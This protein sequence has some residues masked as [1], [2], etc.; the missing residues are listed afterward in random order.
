MNDGDLG[1]LL[2]I[3]NLGRVE[4]I[5]SDQTS[6]IAA[7]CEGNYFG[8]ATF[9]LNTRRTV[10]VKAVS[11]VQ[12]SQLSKSDFEDVLSNFPGQYEIIT[13]KASIQREA[14]GKVNAAVAKNLKKQKISRG[15]QMLASEGLYVSSATRKKNT[16]ELNILA[17]DNT[18]RLMWSLVN[19]LLLGLVLFYIPF[20]IAFLNGQDGFDYLITLL[21]LDL[22]ID[23]IYLIDIYLKF[24]HFGFEEDGELGK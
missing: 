13:K 1:N 16:K 14:D 9:M 19:L 12:T 22:L 7:L 11:L 17:P 24:Y 6:V 23:V 20:R 15:L 10:Y 5:A 3:I 21:P 18:L 8:E 2:F 4:I